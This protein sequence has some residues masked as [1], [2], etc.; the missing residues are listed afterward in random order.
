MAQEQI[1]NQFMNKNDIYILFE[2]IFLVLK[3]GFDFVTL[4]FIRY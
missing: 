3:M 2:A 1:F 4:D